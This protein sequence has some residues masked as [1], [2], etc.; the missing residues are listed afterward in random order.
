MIWQ[1]ILLSR[2]AEDDRIA[3]ALA[4]VFGLSDQDVA[5]I[6]DIT[7]AEDMGDPGLIC[8]RTPIEGDFVLQLTVMPQAAAAVDLA[9]RSEDRDLV[10]ALGK[11]LGAD[12]LIANDETENPYAYSLIRTDGEGAQVHL[13]PDKLDDGRYVVQERDVI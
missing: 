12:C 3:A 5:I 4:R 6:D 7:E 9:E 10:L 2:T 13:D 1:D 8:E 11:A